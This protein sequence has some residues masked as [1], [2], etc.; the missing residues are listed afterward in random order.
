MIK[1]VTITLS[2]AFATGTLAQ[3]TTYA[4]DPATTKLV[5]TGKKVTGQHHGNINV[6]SGSVHWGESG[7]TK[8][9]VIIDMTS[10]TNL[11]MNPESASKLIGHLKSTDFFNTETYKTATFKTSTVDKKT[12]VE[13]GMPNY[14]VAGDL[15]IK[16]VTKPVRFD[17]LAWKEAGIVRAA[18]TIVFDRTLYDIKYRSGQFFDA[19]GDKM[20]NDMVELTFDLRGK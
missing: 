12:G 8:A 11:D 9:E 15:T 20:I 3:S 1:A 13:A 2:L 10:I 14:T 7:L 16:G 17:V 18:G 6:D 4:V 19:L 5:W